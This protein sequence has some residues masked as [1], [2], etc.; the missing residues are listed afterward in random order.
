ME[1]TIARYDREWPQADQ[2]PA[3]SD[4][5]APALQPEAAEEPSVWPK[6]H[7]IRDN[8][9]GWEYVDV[10]PEPSALDDYFSRDTNG[11]KL[12]EESAEYYARKALGEQVKREL[13]LGTLAVKLGVRGRIDEEGKQV[14]DWSHPIFHSPNT[15]YTPNAHPSTLMGL[16]I[17]SPLKKRADQ[18][19]RAPS[20]SRPGTH[21]AAAGAGRRRRAAS[22]PAENTTALRKDNGSLFDETLLA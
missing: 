9:D 19:R 7:Q 4:S 15:D 16:D 18:P 17:R 10:Q 22:I 8:N 13:A 3:T 2:P 1:T 12:R 20:E 14:I 21:R 6:L 11:Y 5:I